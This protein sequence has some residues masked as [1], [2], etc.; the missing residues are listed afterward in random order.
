VAGYEW[1]G[2][3]NNRNNINVKQEQEAPLPFSLSLLPCQSVVTP[4][5]DPGESVFGLLLSL[6]NSTLILS[7]HEKKLK[8]GK[9]KNYLFPLLFISICLPSLS[10]SFS[11]LPPRPLLHALNLHI[12]PQLFSLNPAI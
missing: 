12:P 4:S 9:K 10:L 11:Y 7:L 3:S 2:V 8:K 5:Y 1:I 6:E